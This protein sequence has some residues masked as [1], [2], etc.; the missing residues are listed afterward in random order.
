MKKKK[1]EN[2]LQGL[3]PGKFWNKKAHL[4]HF[5]AFRSITKMVI[6]RKKRKS[7]KKLKTLMPV[8]Y[9]HRFGSVNLLF[10]LKG[11]SGIVLMKNTYLETLKERD[12]VDALCATDRSLSKV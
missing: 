8:I 1:T 12:D 2:I 5:G 6:G 4:E 3:S 11:V 9:T 10:V 7:V